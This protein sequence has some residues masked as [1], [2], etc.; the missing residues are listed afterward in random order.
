MLEAV[1]SKE[2]PR[3]RLRS[4]RNLMSTD[5]LSAGVVPENRPLAAYT[6]FG[7]TFAGRR[8]RRQPGGALNESVRLPPFFLQP[9][10][11]SP[12]GT[13]NVA[14]QDSSGASVGR[15]ST[16]FARASIL[17]TPRTPFA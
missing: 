6:P 9:Y 5:A 7:G 11:I 17:S 10:T 4:W 15:T 3:A 2:M 1:R 8:T 14:S 16:V 13:G 12:S